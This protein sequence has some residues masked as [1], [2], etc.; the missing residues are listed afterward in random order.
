LRHGILF[1]FCLLLQGLSFRGWDYLLTVRGT[2]DIPG[3]VAGGSPFGFQSLLGVIAIVW[4]LWVKY[5][6]VYAAGCDVDR[7]WITGHDLFNAVT[8]RP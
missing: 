1:V 8:H 7:E 5:G 2:W 6:I 4:V 3:L